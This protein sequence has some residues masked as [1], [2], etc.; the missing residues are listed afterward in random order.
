MTDS[1]PN[2]NDDAPR[3]HPTSNSP[4]LLNATLLVFVFAMLPVIGFLAYLNLNKGSEAPTEII[5]DGVVE[6]EEENAAE[7]P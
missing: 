3:R 1:E 4:S 6:P 2:P 5:A 7:S